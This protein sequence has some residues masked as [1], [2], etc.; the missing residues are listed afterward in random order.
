MKPDAAARKTTMAAALLAVVMWGAVPVGS[1]PAFWSPEGRNGSPS[2]R[3][4]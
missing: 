1:A 2:V 4:A 3:M